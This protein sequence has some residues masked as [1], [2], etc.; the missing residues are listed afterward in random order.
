MSS[1]ALLLKGNT[2]NVTINTAQFYDDGS[3]TTRHLVQFN[4]GDLTTYAIVDP[5]NKKLDA[6][7]SIEIVSGTPF[8]SGAVVKVKN[9][10]GE[11]VTT[12][13]FDRTNRVIEVTLDNMQGEYTAA[14]DSANQYGTLVLDGTGSARFTGENAYSK[15]SFDYTVS[16]T[17]I[18]L[19]NPSSGVSQII[20]FTVD[21]DAKTYSGDNLG[22]IDLE[23]VGGE[24][25]SSSVNYD[26]PVITIGENKYVFR[27][28]NSGDGYSR[29]SYATVGSEGE[30]GKFT[31]IGSSS[32]CGL[33]ADLRGD[34]VI[35]TLD[36]TSYVY[37][38][39]QNPESVQ[40]KISNG[41]FV[42]SCTD[43]GDDNIKFTFDNITLTKAE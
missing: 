21:T 15:A 18:T 13:K 29:F 22:M 17:T 12:L 28:Y 3:S 5:T 4:A 25:V 10:T 26:S 42:I 35:L 43:F 37:D 11:D 41:T 14:T 40:I 23:N 7:L 2:E 24:G 31:Y 39:Y 33:V 36:P 34:E 1:N 6:N 27:F 8:T 9:S 38:R 19:T 16:G 30:V 32:Y 20:E